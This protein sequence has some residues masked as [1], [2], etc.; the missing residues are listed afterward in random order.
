MHNLTGYATSPLATDPFNCRFFVNFVEEVAKCKAK[1]N[2][3]LIAQFGDS[4]Y[5]RGVGIWKSL[6]QEN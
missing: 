3:A 6:L 1:T 2:C 4:L 5:R